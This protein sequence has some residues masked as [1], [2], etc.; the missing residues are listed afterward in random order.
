M[1]A[2]QDYASSENLVGRVIAKETYLSASRCISMLF[3]VLCE[4]LLPGDMYLYV[5]VII[6]SL[7]PIIQVIYCNHYH[8]KRDSLKTI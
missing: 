8:K 2:L 7:F 4:K 6:L 3:I 5:S 1:N